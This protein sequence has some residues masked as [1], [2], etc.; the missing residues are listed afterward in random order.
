MS[1][2]LEDPEFSFSVANSN[3]LL[4]QQHRWGNDVGSYDASL[5]LG[6]QQ[7]TGGLAKLSANVRATYVLLEEVKRLLEQQRR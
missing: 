6:L 7:T 1:S 5:A 3:F 2:P 4:A